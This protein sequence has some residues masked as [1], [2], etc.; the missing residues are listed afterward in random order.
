MHTR[1]SEAQILLITDA[2]NRRQ[3]RD[4]TVGEDAKEERYKDKQQQKCTVTCEGVEIDN[5]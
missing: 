5:V 3:L 4:K 1:N 2:H